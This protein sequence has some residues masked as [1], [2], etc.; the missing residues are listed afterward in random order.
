MTGL[1]LAIVVVLERPSLFVCLLFVS[2]HQ[3]V[4]V[5]LLLLLFHAL[6]RTWSSGCFVR[7]SGR[8]HSAATTRSGF[9]VVVA[10]RTGVAVVV[11]VVERVVEI[12][13]L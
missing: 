3:L 4:G 13:E 9:A 11:M 5:L 6:A 2:F 10:A 1:F 12:V 8:F 7:M